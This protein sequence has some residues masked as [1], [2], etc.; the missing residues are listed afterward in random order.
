[1]MNPVDVLGDRHRP[2][3]YGSQYHRLVVHIEERNCPERRGRC[4]P[5]GSLCADD[6]EERRNIILARLE[7]P[8]RVD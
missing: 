8:G 5:C 3:G 6:Q 7:R 1:M 2:V 4:V